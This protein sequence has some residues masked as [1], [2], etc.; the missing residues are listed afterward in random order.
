MVDLPDFDNR[1]AFAIKLFDLI[2]L[3]EQHGFAVHARLISEEDVQIIVEGVAKRPVH[4]VID[5]RDV[6][7]VAGQGFTLTQNLHIDCAKAL[8]PRLASRFEGAD[9]AHS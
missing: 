7:A 4:C 3:A 8:D 2:Q 1:R 5:G 6:R 9:H